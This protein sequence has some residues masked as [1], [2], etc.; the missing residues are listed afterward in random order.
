VFLISTDGSKH[1]HPDQEA[2]AR[3]LDNKRRQ[4]KLVFNYVS[5]FN[6]L[7]NS[8]TLKESAGY[9]TCYASEENEG[10]KTEI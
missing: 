4:V 9:T 3:I 7:W 1:E 5:D 2:I 6:S 10:I 8:E